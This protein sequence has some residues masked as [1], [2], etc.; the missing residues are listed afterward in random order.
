MLAPAL[1]V[2]VK[3]MLVLE[4]RGLQ[5]CSQGAAM[6]SVPWRGAQE[7]SWLTPWPFLPA[8]WPSP[9]QTLL[10]LLRAAGKPSCVANRSLPGLAALACTCLELGPA[11]GPSLAPPLRGH[12]A[13]PASPA[14]P[15]PGRALGNTAPSCHSLAAARSRSGLSEE[16][17]LQTNQLLAGTEDFYSYHN[18]SIYKAVN[19]RGR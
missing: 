12:M 1:S 18:F 7:G 10:C 5:N 13:P 17:G 2:C 9:T 14:L 3:T 8:V 11:Q 16:R 19:E 4:E 6:P 15:R